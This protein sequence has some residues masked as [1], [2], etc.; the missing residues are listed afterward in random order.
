MAGRLVARTRHARG[1][2]ADLEDV[3]GNAGD[4]IHGASAVGLW[5]A[6]VF[7]FAGLQVHSDGWTL[8]PKLPAHWKRLAFKFDWRGEEVSIDLPDKQA[9]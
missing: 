7:G 8:L 9:G 1:S 5:Q 4:G 2:C 3:R 6:M